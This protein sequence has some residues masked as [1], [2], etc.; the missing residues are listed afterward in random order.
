MQDKIKELMQKKERH[1]LECQRATRKL[2]EIRQAVQC[3]TGEFEIQERVT[4]KAIS[5][6]TANCPRINTTRLVL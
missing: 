6:A 5:N 3:T 1:R 4:K 2:P